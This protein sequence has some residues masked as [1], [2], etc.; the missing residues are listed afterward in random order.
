MADLLTAI[1]TKSLI[2]KNFKF[3]SELSQ[4]VLNRT[5]TKG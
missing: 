1:I 5:G 4:N 3:I 2:L